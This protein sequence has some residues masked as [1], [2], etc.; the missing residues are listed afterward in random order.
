MRLM[1]LHERCVTAGIDASRID[2]AMDGGAPKQALIALLLE[3][4]QALATTPRATMDADTVAESL[5]AEA[6]RAATLD[7]LEALAAPIPSAVALAAALAL[8]DVMATEKERAA[9]DRCTL[10]LGR[11]LGWR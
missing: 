7:H 9:F 11:L 3:H 1:A 4:R 6:T 5:R 10:L 2:D 8:V